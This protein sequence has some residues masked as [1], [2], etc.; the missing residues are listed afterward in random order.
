M[1]VTQQPIKTEKMNNQAAA[2]KASVKGL[3]KTLI[4]NQACVDSA[5]NHKWWVAL[6]FFVASMGLSIIPSTV[7]TATTR[8]D[9]ILTNYPYSVDV[10]LEDFSRK[11]NGEVYDSTTESRSID[12]EKVVNFVISP[13]ENGTNKLSIDDTS[14]T[15]LNTYVFTEKLTY[16]LEDGTVDNYKYYEYSTTTGEYEEDNITP[17]KAARLRVFY[18][19]DDPATENDE[20]ATFA[21]F[22]PLFGIEMPDLATDHVAYKAPASLLVLG[23][24]SFFFVK[25]NTAATTRAGYMNVYSGDYVNTSLIDGKYNLRL[26]AY[27]D[28]VTDLTAT[29]LSF[30]ELA[31]SQWL[32][33][34]ENGYKT[35]R[36]RTTL[37]TFLVTLGMNFVLTILFGFTLWIMCRGKNNP[38]RHYKF[39]ENL[40]MA[41]YASLTPAILTI[42]VGFM[43]PQIASYAFIAVMAIRLMWMSMKT[44]RPQ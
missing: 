27:A 21:R 19:A 18:I 32:S 34:F 33:F 5:I 7:N 31:S 11:L 10:G 2:P 40:F 14:L 4:S 30:T 22:D 36:N 6:L 26:L 24:N 39:H 17:K 23:T 41:F 25:Y 12:S 37:V 38:N 20:A 13:D 35:L 1:K 29:E 44:F 16:S 28:G 42:I 3:F 8:G 15:N 43:F 9:N